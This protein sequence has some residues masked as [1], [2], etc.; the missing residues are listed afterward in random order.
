LIR[1]NQ[2]QKELTITET[3]FEISLND[4]TSEGKH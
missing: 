2:I 3:A 1:L 4:L